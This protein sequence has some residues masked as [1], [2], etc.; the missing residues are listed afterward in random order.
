M[1]YAKLAQAQ[2]ESGEHDAAEVTVARAVELAEK[3]P[4]PTAERYQIHAT[5]AL[6]KE[7]YEKAAHDLRR[8]A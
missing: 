8:A 4:L 6:V 7:D 3:A 5:A 2:L 1:A